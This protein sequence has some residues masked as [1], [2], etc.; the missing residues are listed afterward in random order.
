MT[1]SRFAC[2]DLHVLNKE[3]Y[4]QLVNLFDI[5]NDKLHPELTRIME[6]HDLWET[7]YIQDEIRRTFTKHPDEMPEILPK[8]TVKDGFCPDTYQFPIFTGT[9]DHIS[10]FL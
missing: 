1:N 9:S 6:N 10:V 5:L 4:G 7:R 8:D 2:S 3:T